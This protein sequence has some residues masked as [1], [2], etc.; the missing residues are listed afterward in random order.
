[1]PKTS[2]NCISKF[3]SVTAAIVGLREEQ[4]AVEIVYVRKITAMMELT[5]INEP[6]GFIRGVVNLQGQVIVVIDLA[7]Q[8]GLMPMKEIPQTARIIFIEFNKRMFGFIVEHVIDV[9]KVSQ[10][11]DIKNIFTDLT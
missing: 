2:L 1:M 7:G 8:L 5:L 10:V 3:P 11:L 6:T 9:A 4:L